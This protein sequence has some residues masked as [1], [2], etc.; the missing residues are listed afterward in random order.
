LEFRSGIDCS[1]STAG[2]WVEPSTGRDLDVKLDESSGPYTGTSPGGKYTINVPFDPTKLTIT[3]TRTSDSE[4]VFNSHFTLGSGWGFSPDDDR[5]VVHVGSSG[6]HFVQ[7]YNLDTDSQNNLIAATTPTQIDSAYVSF[8]SHG[9]YLL[10]SQRKDASLVLDVIDVATGNTELNHITGM[11]L[12]TPPPPDEEITIAGWGFSPDSQDASFVY[13]WKHSLGA[14]VKVRNLATGEDV[15]EDVSLALPYS[16]QTDKAWMFSPCGDLWAIAYEESNLFRA[17]KTLD[18]S[19]ADD[20]A[21]FNSTDHGFFQ[22]KA[23]DNL[24]DHLVYYQGGTQLTL[25][26]ADNVA[27]LAC[28]IDTDNDGILDEVDNCPLVHNPD[29]IDINPANGVGDACEN[30]QDGDGVWDDVDNCPVVYN[31]DQIDVDPANGIGDACETANDNT[32][33][34]WPVPS[35]LTTSNVTET[36]LQLSWSEASDGVYQYNLFQ[37]GNAFAQVLASSPRI[38]DVDGLDPWTA[39]I[40]KVEAEDLAENETSNGPQ[41]WVQTRDDSAPFWTVPAFLTASDVTA[42]SMTLTWTAAQDNVAVT[43]YRLYKIV[44]QTSELVATINSGST[45]S[46]TFTCLR[47]STAY[48]FQVQAGDAAGNWSTGDLPPGGPIE[49]KVTLSGPACDQTLERASVSSTGEQLVWSELTDG[50]SRGASISNDGRYIVFGSDAENIRVAEFAESPELHVYDRDTDRT[51]PLVTFQGDTLAAYAD[52]G[53]VDMSGDGNWVAYSSRAVFLINNDTNFSDDIFV[54]NRSNG[55]TERVSVASNGDEAE[56]P[57]YNPAISGDGRY[58]AFQSLETFGDETDT[59]NGVDVFVHDRDLNTTTRVSVSSTG[60]QANDAWVQFPDISDDG[61]Y[62][63]FETSDSNLVEDDTNICQGAGQ[64]GQIFTFPCNDVFIHDRQSGETKRVS[65][66]ASGGEVTGVSTTT[67]IS[68]N[69]RFVVFQSGATAFIANDS[70]DA[71]DIYLKDML[72]GKVERV[73]VSSDD[74]QANDGSWNPEIS[75]NGRFVTFE[76]RATNLDPADT[77]DHIDVFVHDRVSG[78][79]KMLS[80]CACGICSNDLSQRPAINGD[81]RVIAFESDATNLLVGLGDT[82]STVDVFLHEWEPPAGDDDAIPDSGEFGP[83]SSDVAYDGNG[84]EIID[85]SQSHVVSV[86][87]HDTQYYFT[88]AGPDGKVFEEFTAIDNPSPDTA[89]AGMEFPWGLFEFTI[90]GLDFGEAFTID[91]FVPQGITP[92]H[93]FMWAASVDE[94]SAHWYEFNYDAVTGAVFNGNVITLHLKNGA[95]GDDD[96][97]TNDNT[98]TLRG[99]P[100]VS[101]IAEADISVSPTAVDFGAVTVGTP[102]GPEIITISNTGGSDLEITDLT[103]T[104]ADALRYDLQLDVGGNPCGST[105]KIL[106]SLSNC[107]VGIVFT[108]LADGEQVASLDI[109]SNDPDEATVSISLS[110]SSD[111]VPSQAIEVTPLTHNFGTLSA[112]TTSAPVEVEIRNTGE[113]ALKI[114]SATLSAQPVFAFTSAELNNCSETPFFLNPGQSCKL[115][116]TFTPVGY[117]DYLSIL[118]IE[119]DDINTPTFPVTLRGSGSQVLVTSGI[120]VSPMSHSFGHVVTGQTSA[121]VV[122]SIYNVGGGDL[123]ISAL[124]GNA[125]FDSA[126]LLVPD[127]GIDACGNPPFSVTPG[128]SCDI[129]VLF[130]PSVAGNTIGTLS[131]ESNDPVQPALVLTFRGEATDAL[132]IA[133]LHLQPEIVNFGEVLQG[134]ESLPQRVSLTNRSDAAV[135]ISLSEFDPLLNVMG[136]GVF[137]YDMTGQNTCLTIGGIEATVLEPGASC[138][139]DLIYRPSNEAMT[140]GSLVVHGSDGELSNAI[141]LQGQMLPINISVARNLAVSPASLVFSELL[142]GFETYFMT[143]TRSILLRNTGEEVLQVQHVGLSDVENFH[144]TPAAWPGACAEAPFDMLSGELCELIVS[145]EP[146]SVGQHNA[147]IAINSNDPDSAITLIS[148]TGRAGQAEHSANIVLSNHHYD[149]GQSLTNINTPAAIKS[150][151]LAINNHGFIDLEITS[152]TLSDNENFSV[153]PCGQL[154]ITVSVV[155]PCFT[156]LLFNPDE[157]GVYTAS[158]EIQSNDPDYPVRTVNLTGIGVSD[159]DGLTDVEESGPNGDDPSFDG[160]TDGTPDNQQAHVSSLH[161]FNQSHYVTLETDDENT[162]LSNVRAADNPSPDNVPANAEFPLGFFDFT[163]C[164]FNQG[165]AKTLTIIVPAAVNMPNTYYK[166]GPTPDNPVDHWYEFLFDGTTGAEFNGNKIILHFVDGQRGDDDLLENGS[167]TDIGGPGSRPTV[168]PKPIEDDGKSDGG[169]CFI[170]TAA[171]GSYLDPDVKVLR[172]FRDN[173]LLTNS[174]GSAVVDFYYANSPPIADFIRQDETL[175]SLVRWALTPIVFAV[176]H[177]YWSMLLLAM[178]TVVIYRRRWQKRRVL[179]STRHA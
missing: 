166:F 52:T 55:Q 2:L 45:L 16:P 84:D 6:S 145:Y 164:C 125:V 177:I 102:T 131:I 29:Q 151:D 47:P 90:T 169:F 13:A 134:N 98:L 59:N 63:V 83:D 89:P 95:R 97:S 142:Y 146:H 174:F 115:A 74:E 133:E 61:R 157:T 117:G 178:F 3:I 106:D 100:A 53:H 149:F 17:Y 120:A 42:N 39:Y 25:P 138:T 31:P 75:A 92:T 116:V 43:R 159:V 19:H 8:S 33:P 27:A 148:L 171:Y 123:D 156:K 173:Y 80:V 96:L 118:S 99:G 168:S 70:N 147:V 176:K 22:V 86:H 91:I 111:I 40:F 93:F 1:C 124:N 85:A 76:S 11:T 9:K 158:L 130:Q 137:D 20:G 57:S 14:A 152:L 140:E 37:D 50:Q 24:T 54:T 150:F 87:N 172:D 153:Q 62:V 69:G 139:Y 48:T 162:A 112:G 135:S 126:Y 36:S 67:S 154:P 51:R 35:T 81:G 105:P 160:N 165:E 170:A 127:V 129:Q 144:V 161:T 23:E 82:N 21:V 175:R 143:E 179:I 101:V 34:T 108:A 4:V 132:Q 155:N 46:Y 107:T 44:D 114:I 15:F 167:I 141:V 60:Q 64:M 66:T 18:G 109:M 163:L 10:Y 77:N 7:L 122:I 56:Y 71:I 26:L 73:S 104:G 28:E 41:A 58:V 136:F 79:T 38:Y 121:P 72:T 68:A 128:D 78:V 119:S 32:P 49:Q 103:I 12:D 5:F 110:G 94:G 88:F 65:V 113:S 30:D